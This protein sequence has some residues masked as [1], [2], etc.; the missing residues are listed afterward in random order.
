MIIFE[1]ILTSLKV[2][3]IVK[4]AGVVAIIGLNLKSNQNR[5]IQYV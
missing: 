4:A 1:S 2:S 3:V 5:E